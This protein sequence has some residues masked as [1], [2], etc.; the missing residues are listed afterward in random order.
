MDAA[1]LHSVK[2]RSPEQG[3]RR[4][5]LASMPSPLLLWSRELARLVVPV[6]CPGCGLPDVRCCGA[7]A[8]VLTAAP[9][10]VERAAPRLDRLDGVPP[11]PVWALAPYTGVVRG[12]V[13][14]WKDRGRADLDAL[15]AEE[16]RRAAAAIAPGVRGAAPHR[17]VLVVP[18]PS[19]AAARRQ[20][21]REPVRVLA[22][23]VARGLCD[24]GTAAVVVPALRRRG[25][26]RDQV[27]LGSRARGRNL[28]TA[29]VVRRR[30]LERGRRGR[31]LLCLL[32]DDVVTT[33]A[34]LAAAESAL[35][36]AGA[37]V[38]GAVVL[39]A[40]PPPDAVAD[41]THDQPG[42]SVYQCAHVGIA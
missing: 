34:T 19:S 7:C 32:V 40:T 41:P 27:G 12:L 33:G 5:M 42:P 8:A 35:E 1:A 31:T 24:G 36:A 15:F 9:D 16:L 25:R 13:V 37:S 14:T 30:M 20:R 39:A 18:A 21:G 4:G 29:V 17:R 6:Q 28:A 2:E 38:L 26:A 23:A 10:R 3:S 22:R 11:L